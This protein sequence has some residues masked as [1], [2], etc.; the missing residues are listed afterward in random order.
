MVHGA[1]DYG[2]YAPKATI[3]SIEDLGEL[4]VRLGS[5]VNFDRKGDVMWLDDFEDDISKWKSQL[6]GDRG[7][8]LWSPN[9]PH[10]K[11]FSLKATTGATNEDEVYLSKFFAP[12]VLSRIGYEYH[13]TSHEKLGYIIFALQVMEGGSRKLASVK[14]TRA[15]QLWQR[16]VTDVGWVDL[17]P[18]ME[19][20]EGEYAYNTVKFVLDFVTNYQVSLIVN[21]TTYDLSSF[22]LRTRD[23][24]Y[25]DGMKAEITIR[26]NSAAAAIIYFDSVIIT[27]NEP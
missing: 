23:W 5:I 4:A 19:L 3:I 20:E 14:Y 9:H 12:P 10:S 16:F 6:T 8:V 13:F 2:I 21:K 1:P 24:D 22:P 17:S 25:E 15:T 7:S 11:G 18:T 27:Q 26:N